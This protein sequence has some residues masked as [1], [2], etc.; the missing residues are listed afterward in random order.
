MSVARASAPPAVQDGLG[1]GELG[2]A[3]AEGGLGQAHG[4]GLALAQGLDVR[5]RRLHQMVRRNCPHLHR[6]PRPTDAHKFVGM[7]L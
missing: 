1:R 2:L 4:D 7:D 5:V 6:K 3:Q